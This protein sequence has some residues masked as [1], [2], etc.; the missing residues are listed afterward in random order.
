MTK[1]RI[2]GAEVQQ[3]HRDELSTEVSKGSE[4]LKSADGVG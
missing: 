2:D 1:Q 4:I 3:L